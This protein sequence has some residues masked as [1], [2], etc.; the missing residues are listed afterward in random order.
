MK[1]VR[2]TTFFL[3]TSFLMLLSAEATAQPATT[4]FTSMRSPASYSS[5]SRA[6]PHSPDEISF[7]LN[8]EGVKLILKGN[9]AAGQQRIEQALEYN[10]RNTTALYN[11][12]GLY[13]T[14]G[15]PEKAAEVM[16]RAVDITPDDLAFLNRLAEAHF[17]ASNLRGAISTYEKIVSE[18]PEFEK[19]Y[20]RLGALYG[21]VQEWDLAEKALRKALE[22]SPNDARTISN[23][24]SVLVVQKKYHE[25]IRLIDDLDSSDVN[26]DILTT[27]GVA[28]EGMGKKQ[29][30]LEQF[31]AAAQAGKRD[32]EFLGKIRLLRKEIDG[33][34]H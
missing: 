22:Q 34:S 11:L 17:A 31:E 15:A 6:V 2:A 25:A 24:A 5:A 19:S 26:A 32:Q 12:A 3:S 16:S 7:R 33:T 9:R 8:E 13:L 21:M 10:P 20:P 4:K 14:N 23:L 30:A 29:A 27:K 1:D 18:D 28:Y